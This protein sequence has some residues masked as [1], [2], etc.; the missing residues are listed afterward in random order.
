MMRREPGVT[1]VK[2]PQSILGS[3]ELGDYLMLKLLSLL[4]PSWLS[5]MLMKMD[6][7]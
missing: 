2:S 4:L 5:L 3:V 7:V 6:V 1:A